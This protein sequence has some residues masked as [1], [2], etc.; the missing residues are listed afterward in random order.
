MICEREAAINAFVPQEYW[1]IKAMLEKEGFAK[2]EATL[3][4]IDGKKA[5]ISNEESATQIVADLK[6]AEYVVG[7][8]ETK[9]VRRRPY[10][11]FITST[12]QQEASRKLRMR[13]QRTMRLAQNLYEGI[14]VPGEGSVALITYMRTDSVRISKDAQEAA[15]EYIL[16]KYGKEFYP[17]NHVNIFKNKRDAQDA[18]EAVR[19]TSME[20]TPERLA[21]HLTKEH[22]ALY[23]L[24]WNRFLASQMAPAVFDQTTIEI[25]ADKK[26]LLRATGSI[27]K[28]QGF[29]VLYREVSEDNEDGEEEDKSFPPLKKDDGL[30][31]KK[32]LP[33]QHFTKPPPRFTEA[34]L[35]KAL[36]EQGIGRPSTYATIVDTIQKRKY[37]DRDKARLAPTD[38]GTTVNE[39]LIESFPKI[40]DVE[41]T[42]KME[43]QLDDVEENKIDWQKLLSDFYGPFEDSLATA[44]QKMRNVKAEATPTDEVCEECGK[45]MVIRWG[46]FGRFMACSGY[47]DC[48]NTKELGGDGE[49]AEPDEAEKAAAGKTCPTC[50]GPMIVKR[51]R[52]GRF[53]SCKAYPECKTALPLGIGVDCPEPECEGGEVVERKSKK[54]RQFY[55]CSK[56]PD[57]TFVSWGKPRKKECPDCGGHFLVEKYTRDGKGT[58]A[59]PK[60]GCKYKEEIP[61]EETVS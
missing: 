20:W 8:V 21:P 24:I 58:L 60:K 49:A 4:R 25:N 40:L 26:Y 7:K 28:S 30:A 54:G 15:L 32:I 51:G 10:A 31:C 57:C 39:L 29:L 34:S 22:L 17:P 42:A 27:V 38:L 37:V 55:G 3:A 19:P 48:R 35:I 5:E 16:E 59:C 9:E 33:N 6:K 41:F 46:R 36:E 61:E 2:F 56:Y 43:E 14:E 13:P 18:H 52:T 12:L 47:P 50:G 11:P 45:G 23:T 44:S 53:L 1:S